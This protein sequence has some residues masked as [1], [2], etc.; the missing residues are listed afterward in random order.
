MVHI[1]LHLVHLL[2]ALLLALF[3]LPDPL[4]LLLLPC[5]FVFLQS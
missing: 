3:H 2:S 5:C 1:H 4:Q